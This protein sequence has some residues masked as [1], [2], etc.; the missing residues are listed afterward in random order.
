MSNE[1]SNECNYAQ[2][3]MSGETRGA[4]NSSPHK[5]LRDNVGKNHPKSEHKQNNRVSFSELSVASLSLL[6]DESSDHLTEKTVQL[7]KISSGGPKEPVLPEDV[8]T[9]PSHLKDKP[10]GFFLK[11]KLETSVSTN[12]SP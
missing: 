1:G 3:E 5:Q 7:R 9:V 12:D 11:H 6:R 2:P 4:A 10:E 8:V